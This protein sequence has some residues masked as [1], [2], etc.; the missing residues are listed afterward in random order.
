MLVIRTGGTGGS[1]EQNG[2]AAQS[3]R[4]GPDPEELY[5]ANQ[6]FGW[7]SRGPR[8]KKTGQA[9]SLDD[10]VSTIIALASGCDTIEELKTR[11]ESVFADDAAGVTFSSVHKAKGT[12]ANRTFILR[13]DLMPHPLASAG[14]ETKQ[15]DNLQYVALTRSKL[16]MYFV[17]GE[18]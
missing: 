8:S 1:G 5:L 9:M 10:Q 15:E 16:E 12:E 11:I 13:P 6:D 2:R 3:E 7:S 17:R 14:W 18:D 4:S